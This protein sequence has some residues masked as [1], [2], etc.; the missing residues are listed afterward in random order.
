MVLPA[1]WPLEIPAKLLI[2]FCLH[3]KDSLSHTTKFSN[4]S[5]MYFKSFW[6]MSFDEV[7]TMTPALYYQ[8]HELVTFTNVTNTWKNKLK[9]NNIY[10]DSSLQCFLTVVGWIVDEG[11]R[12]SWISWLGVNSEDKL[13][14]KF[15]NFCF[16][17]KPTNIIKI[18]FVLIS[19]IGIWGCFRLTV[20]A[21]YDLPYALG[22]AWCCPLQIVFAIVW[23][24]EL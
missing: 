16:L 11:L 18:C 20:A 17:K 10:F 24:L 19:A 14:W 21:N 13:W 4:F 12:Q 15:G 8:F 1:V 6:T 7:I 23:C 5:Y 2:I 9:G 22:K 3:S